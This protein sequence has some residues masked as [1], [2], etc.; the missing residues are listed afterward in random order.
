MHAT[1]YKALALAFALAVPALGIAADAPA[2]IAHA[3]TAVSDTRTQRQE[4]N[5]LREQM[6][7]L[8]RKMADLSQKM[9]DVGP[10]AYAWRYL[11]DPN[12]GMLGIVMTTE[13]DGMHVAAVTPGGP[14]EKAGVR[15]GDVIVAVD[16]KPVDKIQREDAVPQFAA[17]KVGQTIKLTIQRDGGKTE[18]NIGVTAER[19]EPYN[20]ASAFENPLPGDFNKNVHNQVAQAMREAHVAQRAGGQA[21]RAMEHFHFS[22]PWWGLNLVS[23]NPDLGGYFGTDKGV[24]VLS[25]DDDTFKGLKSG[26]VLLTVADQNIQRPEDALRALREQPTGSAVKVRVMRQHKSLT[27]NVKSPDVT[28]MFVP[29]P[30]PPPPP[31][32]PVPPVAGVAPPPPAPPAPPA[33]PADDGTQML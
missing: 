14:A 8:S 31:V 25:A 2:P 27:L 9:G 4:L 21:R 12:R 7:E 17:L 10:R 28:S 24:L 3:A 15:D 16:G 11:A 33:L 19:R 29:P 1:L 13:K 18:L 6:Q 30:P 32:P 26:D 22:T 20:F 5:Q 23:L